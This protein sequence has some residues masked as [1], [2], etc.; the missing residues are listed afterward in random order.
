M[1]VHPGPKRREWRGGEWPLLLL[2]RIAGENKL[3]GPRLSQDDSC[4]G[5]LRSGVARI[6]KAQVCG[7]M[8]SALTTLKADA[9]A[10]TLLARG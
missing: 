3:A 4:V 6:S 10:L 1:R 7:T 8:H 9:A 2:R 5:N